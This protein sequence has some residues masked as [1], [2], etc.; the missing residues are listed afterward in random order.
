MRR[1]F[2][3]IFVGAVF[4]AAAAFMVSGCSETASS[5]SAAGLARPDHTQYRYTGEVYLLRGLANVF[6]TGLDVMN[7]KF[8]ARGVNS[9]VDNHAVWR[10]WADDIIARDKAGK[11]SYPIII[12][13]HSLGANATMEMARYLGDRGI[14]VSYAVSFDPTITGEPGANVDEAINFYLPNGKKGKD[15]NIIVEGT[16]FTGKLY[17]VDVSG[18]EGMNHFNIEKNPELQV[19]VMT[20]TMGLLGTSV[21]PTKPGDNR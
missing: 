4:A 16:G 21:P 1:S 19:K 2:A 13:G 18:V 11:V 7:D 8:H 15:A 20:K 14:H 17:N 5:T 6:S 12:M 9:K 3:G 10:N